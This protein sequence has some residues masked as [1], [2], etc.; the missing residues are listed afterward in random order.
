MFSANIYELVM[1]CRA[2]RDKCTINIRPGIL[3][4]RKKYNQVIRRTQI[5]HVDERG[6][7]LENNV[8]YHQSFVSYFKRELNKTHCG[9]P[10]FLSS[11]HIYFQLQ[12]R[13]SLS[14]VPD[15]SFPR[16][17]RQSYH[18]F[19]WPPGLHDY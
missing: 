15:T 3:F 7:S 18:I 9:D 14:W 1:Q 2:R 11:T 4:H 13:E 16:A 12:I 10:I 6:W 17:I 8:H 19:P 5:T